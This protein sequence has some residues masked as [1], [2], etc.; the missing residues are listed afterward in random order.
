M[1]HIK[2]KS[3]PPLP[4]VTFLLGLL[5]IPLLSRLHPPPPPRPALPPTAL[6]PH[7]ETCAQWL[8]QQR[9][10]RAYLDAYIIGVQKGATSELAM[11]LSHLSVLPRDMAKEWHYL[12][13][14]LDPAH[15]PYPTALHMPYTGPD[16]GALRLAHYL[17]GFPGRNASVRAEEAIPLVDGAAAHNRTLVYDGTVEYMLSARVAFLAHALTPHAKVVLTVR[18]PLRRARS[19]YN[20]MTRV[21][22]AGRR[23]QGLAAVAA[24]PERFHE[25]LRKEM[26]RLGECG[27]D[28]ETARLDRSTTDMLR[29]MMPEKHSFD[30]LLYVT[31]G[32]YHVHIETWRRHF[33]DHRMHFVSFDDVAMGRGEALQGLARFLCIREWDERLLKMYR[34]KG[35][36]KS[37]GERA[38][39]QGLDKLGFETYSGADRYML[40]VLP[41]TREMVD[42]FY[43]AANVKLELMLGRKMW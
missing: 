11:R 20:M 13:R 36:S 24:T 17:S 32:L 6:A 38:A 22:N 29:C 9:Q 39:E 4:L 28:A 19:Q 35:G 37:Y 18:E 30:D 1:N 33:P 10:T 2:R 34:D 26:G 31:R 7:P 43:A 27:Y 14:L 23:R 5:V 16:L 8:S 15:T 25:I 3:V 42:R 40:E 12:E 21:F 41:Q